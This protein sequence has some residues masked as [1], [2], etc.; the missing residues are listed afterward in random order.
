M[1][2]GM[3]N[4]PISGNAAAERKPASIGKGGA[5]GQAA[6]P[7]GAA[8][9]PGIFS[10]TTG[11]IAGGGAGIGMGGCSGGISGSAASAGGLGSSSQ[12]GLSGMTGAPA[13]GAAKPCISPEEAAKGLPEAGKPEAPEG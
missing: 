5:A 13:G 4:P 2:P 7:D 6:A 3:A 9:R 11:G 10:T 12:S 8:P 1:A